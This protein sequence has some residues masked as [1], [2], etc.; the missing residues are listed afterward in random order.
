MSI[1]GRIN[2]KKFDL[3]HPCDDRG[4]WSRYFNTKESIEKLGLEY[5]E[6][7]GIKILLDE[8]IS[9]PTLNDFCIVEY[10]V[11]HSYFA[12]KGI[13]PKIH[14]H[15]KVCGYYFVEVDDVTCRKNSINVTGDRVRRLSKES[16]F[17]LPHEIEFKHP[18]GKNFVNGY[19]VDFHNFKIDWKEFKLW[20]LDAVKDSHWGDRNRTGE[21]YSYQKNVFADGKR[22][23]IQRVKEM[24]LSEV[25]F[26]N[27]TVLDVGCNLGV[28]SLWAKNAGAKSVTGID[29][30]KNFKLLADIYK[31]FTHTKDVTFIE[32][33]I[34][35]EDIDKYG[36]FDIV[37]Y[38][39]VADSLGIPDKLKDITNELLIY[40]GH[41]NEDQR[42]TELRLGE[43]FAI[44]ELAGYTTDRSKRPIFYC[45]K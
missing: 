42:K 7:I 34:I 13:A 18:D 5:K 22:D 40:E 31:F 30:F 32:E 21:K 20:F 19:Y 1:L 39:A 25:D 45:Y 41:A 27:K 6:G 2:L 43:L 35:P 10:C 4:N 44:V 15:G 11:V 16:G 9:G 14:N 3:L 37:F 23:V 33:K 29:C 12:N 24:S 28:M 38:F 8:M 26:D 36:K 17:I